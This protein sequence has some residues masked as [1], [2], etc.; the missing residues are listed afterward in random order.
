MNNAVDRFE[1]KYIPEPNSGCWIWLASNNGR[2]GQISDGGKR[3]PAHRFSYECNVGP[4]APG[5]VV[6]HKCDNTFCVNP[7]HLFAGSQADNISDMS[8]KGRNGMQLRPQNSSL[9]KHRV[10]R[11]GEKHGKA[12][13][14]DAEVAEMRRLYSTGGVSTRELGRLFNVHGGHAAKIVK[15]TIRRG[16]IQAA[17]K[18][19]A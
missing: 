10:V 16:Q 9:F 13:L 18:E 5:E 11:S 15:G 7:H 6:C 2:Y 14:S 3:K 19:Q 1:E 12:T 8:R 4:I 17:L